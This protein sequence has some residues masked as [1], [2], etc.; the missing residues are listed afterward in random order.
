MTSHDLYLQ[1]LINS[2][3]LRKFAGEAAQ[4]IACM[5][6]ITEADSF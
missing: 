1:R 2:F 6:T 4:P 5:V 3:M